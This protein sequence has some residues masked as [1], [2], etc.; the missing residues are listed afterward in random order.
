MTIIQLLMQYEAHIEQ[1]GYEFE[2][3]RTNDLERNII[4]LVQKLKLI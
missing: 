4:E 3:A 2:T 1:F